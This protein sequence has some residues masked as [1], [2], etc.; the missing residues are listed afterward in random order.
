MPTPRVGLS[1]SD[2]S[3]GWSGGLSRRG[4]L[5]FALM[6]LV[7][8]VPYLMIRVA[9]GEISPAML[10]FSRTTLGALILLPIAIAG[11]GLLPAIGRWRWVAAFAAVEI[12]L[13]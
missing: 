4:I 10:V 1:K 13:P 8:G 9:V 5:L 11:G 2:Q 6:S 12:G 3:I 7:W